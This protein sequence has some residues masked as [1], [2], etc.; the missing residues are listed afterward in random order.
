MDDPDDLTQA[1]SKLLDSH[2]YGFQYAVIATAQKLYKAGVFAGSPWR[3]PIAEF[4]VEVRNSSYHIDLIFEHYRRPLFLVGECKRANPALRN[5]CFL[6]AP[7]KE[8][9]SLSDNVFAEALEWP[10]T[11]DPVC[12]VRPLFYSENVYHLGIEV[13]SHERG[14]PGGKGR[15]AIEEAAGQ[16][17]RGMNGL[18]QFFRQSR[19]ANEARKSIQI[20]PVIFTTAQLWATQADLA[21]SDLLTGRLDLSAFPLQ[22]KKWVFLHYPQ[23]PDLKHSLPIASNDLCNDILTDSLY[24]EFI[25]PI[26]IVTAGGIADFFCMS[27]WSV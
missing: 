17:M 13:K 1:L 15:G 27:H 24:T 14:D 21:Q 7:F 26:A 16:A 22:E 8:S 20:L 12:R 11:G 25:R 4:P 19:K 23:S 10:K 9:N 18:M 2:G 3:R 5:W 6:R